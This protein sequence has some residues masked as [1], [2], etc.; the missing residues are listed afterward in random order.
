MRTEI[1]YDFM[2]PEQ[3]FNNPEALLRAIEHFQETRVLV[4]GDERFNPPPDKFEKLLKED[5]GFVLMPT[6]RD[7][8]FLFRGQG[9][10][11]NPCLPTLLREKRDSEH[12]FVEHMRIVEF[13][14]MLKQY[15]S[16]QYFEQEKLEVDYVGLAQH[17]GLNTEVLDLTSDIRT[18]LF[19]AMC[20]YDRVND[21][22]HP[23]SVDKEYVGYVYA[24]PVIGEIMAY[25]GEMTGN[26]LMHDLKVIGL[27]P[28]SRPGSQRG[29]SLHLGGEKS[30]KGYL[31][32][33]SYSKEDSEAYYEE[34]IN[35]RHVWDKDFIVEKTKAIKETETFT[36]DALA[37]ATK[38]Y[39]KGATVSQT[40]RR[41]NAIGF[42]FSNNVSWR[43]S[44]EERAGLSVEFDKRQKEAILSQIVWRSLRYGDKQ[45]QTS[46]LTFEGQQLMI[47]TL[48]GG[49][50]CIEG[51]DSGIK[52]G[53]EDNP[54]MA[55]WSFDMA[56]PQTVPDGNGRV[57]AFDAVLKSSAA[58]TP[59]A[60]AKRAALKKKVQKNVEH[61][62]MRKVWVPN[63]GG[64]LRDGDRFF[65]MQEEFASALN[66]GDLAGAAVL[67][68]K[69]IALV[70]TDGRIDLNKTQFVPP[71]PLMWYSSN[72]AIM[73]IRL[74]RVEDAA[75]CMND[76]ARIMHVSG[77]DQDIYFMLDTLAENRGRHDI[78]SS[79]Y[80]LACDYL[81]MAILCQ[82]TFLGMSLS[83]LWK[84]R[85]VFTKL[86]HADIAR[87]V[88]GLIGLQ[89]SLIATVFK[90]DDPDGSALFGNF[91]ESLNGI[92]LVVPDPEAPRKLEWPKDPFA[93][94]NA[95]LS[96][97]QRKEI[98]GPMNPHNQ[99]LEDQQLISKNWPSYEC[100]D[101]LLARWY[102]N[103]NEKT[104]EDSLPNILQVM[105]LLC[106]EEEKYA[107][108][109][110]K[111]KL[112]MTLLG[113]AHDYDGNLDVVVDE[114]GHFIF[115]PRGII[116]GLYYRGQAKFFGKCK[117][118]LFRDKSA[119]EVFIERVKLCEFS[120]LLRKHPSAQLFV[121]GYSTPLN[122]GSIESHEML[123]DEEALA[124]HYGILTEYLDLTADK[125]VAAFFACTD[126]HRTPS[127]E[128][129]DYLKHT[130]PDSGVIYLYQDVQQKMYSGE[131]H[132]VGLQPFSR[133]VHQAGYVLK[134]KN[135]DNF[136]DQAK[137]IRFRFDSGCS[138]IVYWLYDQSMKIQPE[139]II[140][141]KAKRIVEE[142]TTFSRAALEM[143]HQRY[144]SNLSDDDFRAMVS[145]YDLQV[146]DEP[147]VD[148]T[149]EEL[150]KAKSE[151]GLQNGHL[152]RTV[153]SRQVMTM[154]LPEEDAPDN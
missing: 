86:G 134:M 91:S 25:K 122:D 140:E 129:D 149:Q 120:L 16:V 13:E 63:D 96:P 54:P 40:Q 2:P 8:A 103:D 141:L 71:R 132:P 123:I 151:F 136:N 60:N 81:M 115:L 153:M 94:N 139:E 148:F 61:F 38:R 42:H 130:E 117:P 44:S 12:L 84:A 34:M 119:R 4:D 30:F 24:Y 17:Y 112:A 100:E 23:K 95:S 118:S 29:F 72:R 83:F 127:G 133:P 113:E 111:E 28:F 79:P 41:M 33:F 154:T 92:E 85:T 128:R 36:F 78:F 80:E 108:R 75:F 15:P 32:S 82:Y 98:F 121:D 51:Y 146:Q 48:Q 90:D 47:Q 9:W 3:H 106:Y 37:L 87:F 135:S 58:L 50:P 46:T 116:N 93:G 138:S 55:G 10:F 110:Q 1:P 66:K 131:L 114:G 99:T 27:Q 35:Q 104:H 77:F 11:F 26:F 150:E 43:L 69:M 97:E 124:Q 109:C 53:L 142:T 57:T 59:E 125:W 65:D 147:L 144:F 45:L 70:G 6:A 101:S 21:C 18:A 22:Y 89:S 68:E 7:Y 5:G 14:L 49:E 102:C 31:Y 126:Y 152:M 105:D 39:G 67:D 19:F 145:A 56:R 76:V 74:G 88:D 73:M 62:R 64:Q 143:A 137:A 107:L 20:D 52:F